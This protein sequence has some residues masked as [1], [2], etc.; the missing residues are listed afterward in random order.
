MQPTFRPDPNA[1]NASSCLPLDH[2]TT[3]VRSSRRSQNRFN[4]R[5]VHKYNYRY[6][7][8]GASDCPR[9]PRIVPLLLEVEQVI[10]P[11][12]PLISH[13]LN[14]IQNPCSWVRDHL[15]QLPLRRSQSRSHRSGWILILFS[16]FRRSTQSLPVDTHNP[17]SFPV[18]TKV[19]SFPPGSKSC[20]RSGRRCDCCLSQTASGECDRNSSRAY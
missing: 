4:Q 7:V 13:N 10:P 16:P 18:T 15:V 5:S 19:L 2:F 11:L 6:I 12:S 20:R 8:H 14:A 1:S 9:V 17:L 3:G